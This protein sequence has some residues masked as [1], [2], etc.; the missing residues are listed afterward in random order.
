MMNTEEC[1]KFLDKHKVYIGWGNWTIMIKRVKKCDCDAVIDVSEIGKQAVVT[2]PDQFL[3]K[4]TDIQKS[5][6]FHELVH[7]RVRVMQK[8]LE[9]NEDDE[10]ELMVNDIE[11]LIMNREV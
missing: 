2:L 9:N 11:Q 3:K 8:R 7:G 6:L 1:L 4:P 5:I 10:E